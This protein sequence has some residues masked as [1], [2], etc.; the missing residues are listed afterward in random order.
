MGLHCGVKKNGYRDLALIVSDRSCTA[1]AVFTTNVFKAAPVSVSRD[2][3]AKSGGE[4]I[5]AVVANSG[6]A[7]AVTGVKGIEDAR[8]MA[9]AVDALVGVPSSSLVMSTGVIGKH[10]PIDRIVA[11]INDAY[12]TLEGDH[13]GWMNAANAFRTT[14]TFPK[15]RSG[16]F[17]LPNSNLTYRMAGISKGAGMMHPNMATLLSTICTDVPI[18]ANALHEALQ[19]AADRS[20]NSI[21]VDGD[22]STNDT[23]AVL[24]NGAAAAGDPQ[25]E[26]HDVTREDFLQF[27]EDLTAFAVEL[28]QLVVRDG[29]GATKFVTIK[30]T[31]ICDVYSNSDDEFSHKLVS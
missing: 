3:L 18:S 13:R 23:F 20:F 11:G 17:R 4:G 12:T 5:R 8:T 30:V 19:Y 16:E 25:A 22:T 27:R 21:S 14:D 10:L 24:A 28:A 31:V 9:S 15:L 26:I 29:E 2:L 7:N 6:C 1:A